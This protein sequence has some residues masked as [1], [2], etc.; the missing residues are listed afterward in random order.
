M[1]SFCRETGIK[2]TIIP[3]QLTNLSQGDEYLGTRVRTNSQ[4]PSTNSSMHSGR[5]RVPACHFIRP[6][7][8]LS[9]CTTAPPRR[10]RR[11]LRPKREQVRTNITYGLNLRKRG[12]LA[13]LSCC[14]PASLQLKNERTNGR[15]KKGNIQSKKC[16]RK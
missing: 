7:L 15:K 14:Q 5:L 9:I 6:G 13:W 2:Y 4:V 1:V 12:R 8:N 10:A 16:L 3:A 11:N